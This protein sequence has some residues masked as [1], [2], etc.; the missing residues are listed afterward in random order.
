MW[1]Y[2]CRL[3][4]AGAGTIRKCQGFEQRFTAPPELPFWGGQR[5]KG[6]RLRLGDRAKKRYVTPFLLAKNEA[7]ASAEEVGGR[8]RTKENIG[9]S[10][11]PPAQNGC[12]VSQDLAGVCHASIWRHFQRQEPYAAMPPVRMCAGGCQQWPSLPRPFSSPH[13]RLAVAY[14]GDQVYIPGR[15]SLHT[16][17]S[18]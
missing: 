7:Q 9:Q 5:V 6:V 4:V 17:N 10:H 8:A 13:I 12:G 14:G 1:E 11:A 18:A 2:A 15:A 16:R 3:T